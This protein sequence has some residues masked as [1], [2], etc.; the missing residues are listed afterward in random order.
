MSGAL[1]VGLGVTGRA[2][3]E[4]LAGRAEPLILVEDRPTDVHR[5]HAAEWA[6]ELLEAPD[7]ATLGHAVGRVDVEFVQKG[8]TPGEFDRKPIGE[9]DV[10]G[11]RAIRFDP[12]NFTIQGIRKQ[13]CDGVSALF[14]RLINAFFGV[15]RR[16][17][18]DQQ[19]AV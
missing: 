15:K 16:H 7:A 18:R 19:A 8:V 11:Q 13:R 5:A 6:A 2:V 4:R 14:R 12:P 10:A 9:R 1:V 3:A 17:E